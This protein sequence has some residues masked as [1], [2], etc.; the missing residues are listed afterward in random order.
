MRNDSVLQEILVRLHQLQ[1][2]YRNKNETQRY[3]ENRPPQTVTPWA[4]CYYLIVIR[5]I[6]H[7]HDRLKFRTFKETSTGRRIFIRTL[8]PSFNKT[9]D[10]N[11]SSSSKLWMS[12]LRNRYKDLLALSRSYVGMFFEIFMQIQL[13]VH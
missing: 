2:H 11:Q 13:T 4:L 12:K 6:K 3:G 8:V 9:E 5:S 7:H 1:W 10:A